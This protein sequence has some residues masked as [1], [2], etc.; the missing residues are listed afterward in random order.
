M[1]IFAQIM[2]VY[3]MKKITFL[4]LFL[5]TLVVGQ[6][7]NV[8]VD[9]FINEIDVDQESTD[10]ME[11]IELFSTTPNASL[12][13]LVVVLFNG[14]TS[15]NPANVSYRTVD[16]D[17]FTTDANGFFIIGAD[18]VPGVDVSFGASNRMQNGPDA[19]AL[20]FGN[21]TDFPN[22]TPPTTTNLRDAIVYGT[23]DSDDTDLLMALGETIQYDEDL[24]A[25]SENESLQRE[26]DGTYCTAPPTLDAVTFCPFC[27]FAIT[28]VSSTCDTNTSAVDSTTIALEFEGGGTE[29]YTITVTTGMGTVAGDDPSLN[30]TGFI[31]ITDVDEGTDIT[32][33]I[34]S[35]SCDIE[36]E[37]TA[38]DCDPI[39]PV[40]SLTELRASIPGATYVLTSE[41]IL[42]FQQSERNQKFIEDANAAILIDDPD[43][44]ITTPYNQGDGITGITGILDEDGP[45]LVF[46]PVQN[47][48]SP[49]STGNAVRPQSV[50]MQELDDNPEAYESE[51]VQISQGVDVDTSEFITWLVDETY[52]LLNPEGSFE[53][54]ARFA[55]ANYIG[56]PVPT[57]TVALAGII[58]QQTSTKY[59]ITSRN[60][61]DVNG[62]LGISDVASLTLSI[63]PNPAAAGVVNIESASPSKLDVTISDLS[64]KTVINKK[65]VVQSLDISTL[66]PGLYLI[67]I[68][69]DGRAAV[70]KLIVY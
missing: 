5:S 11:F 1:G 58:V 41:A 53:F 29:T 55:D 70:E 42:T 15:S 47:P 37:A 65:G 9:V 33:S 22:G 68:V 59:T 49:T 25:D 52:E 61:D 28:N 27:E 64:G 16:L 56:Q 67:T 54:R 39:T 34:S 3:T 45:M 18:A 63:Y 10:T 23:G 8:G 44:V 66:Q 62:I 7:K 36:Q 32:V 26:A 13:G 60:S 24:N 40:G 6:T 2:N 12:D 57:S 30:A 17:G 50:S 43:G 20:Y 46:I 31:L 4:F 48:A 35:L 51:F 14:G 21:D 38:L 69:Q 19:V